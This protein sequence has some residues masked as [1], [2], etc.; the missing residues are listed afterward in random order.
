M[1]PGPA[2]VGKACC[3]GGRGGACA[4]VSAPPTPTPEV[5]TVNSHQ[6]CVLGVLINVMRSLVNFIFLLQYLFMYNV[7]IT[8]MRNI[9]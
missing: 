8:Y 1:G 2:R 6:K 3:S 5:A 9:L 4:T 7:A